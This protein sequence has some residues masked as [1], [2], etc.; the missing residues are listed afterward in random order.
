MAMANKDCAFD[1]QCYLHT[2]MTHNVK[3]FTIY[4]CFREDLP[5]N[6]VIRGI[7]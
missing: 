3:H 7:L 6:A 4:N 5:C 2:Q 1:L